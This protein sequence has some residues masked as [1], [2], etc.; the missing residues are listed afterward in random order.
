M[1]RRE[2]ELETEGESHRERYM[3]TETAKYGAS[4]PEPHMRCPVYVPCVR[5]TGI[6]DSPL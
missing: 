4:A 3:K 5:T 6:L 1:R 2:K